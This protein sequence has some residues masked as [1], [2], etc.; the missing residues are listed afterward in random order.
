MAWWMIAL[1]VAASFLLLVLVYDLLQ[2]KH[3]ILRNFPIIG[4]FLPIARHCS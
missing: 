4:H 1:I 3:A 2:T